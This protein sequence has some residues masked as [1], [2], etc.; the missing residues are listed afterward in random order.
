MLFRK[1]NQSCILLYHRDEKHAY[2]SA[3]CTG[4]HLPQVMPLAIDTR[5]PYYAGQYYRPDNPPLHVIYGDVGELQT[6]HQRHQAAHGGH[7]GTDFPP[8]GDYHIDYHG[9]HGGGDEEPEPVRRMHLEEIYRGCK[10]AD[11]ADQIWRRAL[12]A[13]TQ[14][15]VAHHAEPLHHHNRPG[16]DDGGHKKEHPDS[17]PARCRR[18]QSQEGQRHRQ[19]DTVGRDKQRTEHRRHCQEKLIHT[20]IPLY[21]G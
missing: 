5:R 13:L 2:E 11:R 19:Y 17:E 10:I 3:G 14:G 6:E 8:S 12:A 7:M 20:L 18:Q 9:H 4:K 15:V 1:R 21:A 16:R